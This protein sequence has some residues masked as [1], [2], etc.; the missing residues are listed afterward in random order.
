MCGPGYLASPERVIF[1]GA[2]LRAEPV[3]TDTRIGEGGPVSSDLV[4][5]PSASAASDAARDVGAQAT[6]QAKAVA[7]EARDQ[8]GQLLGKTQDELRERAREQS[9]R[10]AGALRNLAGQIS[11]LSDGRSEEAGP[12]AGYLSEAQGKVEQFAE[13]LADRGPQG[14]LEDLAGFA[15]RRPA[16]FLLLAGGAGFAAGR[17]TRSG[18]AARKESVDSS[19]PGSQALPLAP[20]SPASPTTSTGMP[21]ASTGLAAPIE[22][23]P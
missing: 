17:I 12:L 16:V 20:P 15:R 21:A 2:R 22:T 9:D 10:A 23:A 7:G 14:M 18:A 19:P 6:D 5:A 13:R 4:N 1:A 3:G 8:F 11:A